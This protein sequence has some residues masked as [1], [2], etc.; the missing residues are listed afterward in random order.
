MAIRLPDMPA[1]KN[2]AAVASIKAKLQATFPGMS[3]RTSGIA[4][5][6]P[7]MNKE[8]S[9]QLM[10]GFFEALFG[11][12]IVLAI[13]FRSIRWALVGVV[14]NLVPPAMLLGFLALFEVPIKPGI[15]IIFSIKSGIAFDNTIYIL[16]RSEVA[17]KRAAT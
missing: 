10:W 1:D 8:L 2:S 6:V 11:I 12:V 4:A 5:I 9:K 7:P 17:L 13:F 15:A 16:G 3:I 14:P